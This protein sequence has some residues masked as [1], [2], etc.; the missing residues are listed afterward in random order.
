MKYLS[1][2]EILFLHFKIVEEFGGSHGIRDENRVKSA[3]DAPK[4]SVFGQDQYKSI[5]DKAAV[6]ARNIIGDHPFADG[7][8]RTGITVASIFLLRNGY[9]L[10]AK[11][12]DLEDFAV[13]VAVDKLD[14]P[15]IAK[16]LEEN[17]R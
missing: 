4:Q 13:K 1:L 5:H 8:K 12:K 2:E 15:A 17:S 16:W 10:I 14:V 9:Q 11:P 6:Y 7:N 3:V